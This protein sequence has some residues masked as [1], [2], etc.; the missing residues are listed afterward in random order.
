MVE[1]LDLNGMVFGRLTV[2]QKADKR[3]N[4][5]QVMWICSCECG[6]IVT[7]RGGSLT[8]GHTKSCGCLAGTHKLSHHPIY[9]VWCDM[10][11]RCTSINSKSY[12]NYGGRG[13]KVC[14]RWLESVGAFYRDVVANY[15]EGLELD[16]INNDGDYEPSNVRWV[17]HAQNQRN[18]G[19]FKGSS[20]KYKG[21]GW[22]KAANKWTA[23]ISKD[24]RDK[25]LGCFTSE[26]DAALAYN[27]AAKE[28]FGEYAYLNK[29]ET[30]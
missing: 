11:R 9:S 8:S 23:R 20:S 10:I 15:K 17:T 14:D 12:S 16:R 30:N 4:R 2:T 6:N 3:G 13:I 25:Y 26:A 27:I 18:K 22:D 1:K 5:R 19:S 7:T 28:L 29:I 24:G 21:V